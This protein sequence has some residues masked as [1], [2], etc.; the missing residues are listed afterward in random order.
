MAKQIARLLKADIQESSDLKSIAKMLSKKGRGG[1]TMLAHI[2]PKEAK[3]LKEAGGAGTVNP[4]TGLL[5]FYDGGF[6]IGDYGFDYGADYGRQQS[7]SYD[8][9]PPQQAAESPYTFDAG[10]APIQLTAPDIDPQQY[11][12]DQP[13]QQLQQAAVGQYAGSAFPYDLT[14]KEGYQQI[15]ENLGITD[16]SQYK[17]E[18]P[19][20]S[21]AAAYL[22]R[23]L[24][25][26]AGGAVA[27]APA[28]AAE[29]AVTPTQP[30]LSQRVG[31]ILSAVKS[32]GGDVLD[33]LKKNPEL[34]KLA[35]AGAGAVA[36]RQQ[37]QQA[38]RQIQQAVQEQKQIGKP[39][40]EEG[41]K[42]QRAA[43]AGELT[44][45]S[46]QA[47]QAL[48]A[49]MAQGIESRGGV[50]VAQA[51]AQLEAFRQNLLQNQY[52]YGLQVAQI[53]DQYAVGAIRTGLQLDQ[54]L[55]A[56]TQQFYTNLAAIAGG[57]APAR[58][59]Q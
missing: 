59:Q 24:P 21:S 26:A 56:A 48:R 11:Y 14:G 16:W 35:G 29:G 52:N 15:P 51:Q 50:G 10:A 34:L 17:K 55:Q 27:Q 9:I 13:Y 19:E 8:Y 58:T 25:A 31:D 4:D 2:T 28:A 39:Y 22:S 45:Q 6:N 38:A 44:P 1:D 5:E 53:G 20:E 37:A 23:M 30:G 12:A 32:G 54:N 18:F 36:G 40:Q 7:R 33:F 46:A 42:L 47:Y 49:Q 57:I 41:Q 3:I 43:L